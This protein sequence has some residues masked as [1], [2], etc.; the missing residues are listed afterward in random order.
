MKKFLLYG[1]NGYTA[2]LVI[3]FANAYGLEPVLAGRNAAKI[4]KL[5]KVHSLTFEVFSLDHLDEIEDKIKSYDLVL[6]CAGPFIHT[7]KNMMHAC[8][9]TQT[10]YLDITGEIEVF[11]LGQSLSE[12][13]KNSNITLIPGTGFDVVPTDCLA[14]YLKEKM[15]DATHLAL[16]IGS[17]GAVVSH[18]TA[19]TVVENIG[20][21]GFIRADGK[22]KKV[23]TAYKNRI[24]P[25]DGKSLHAMTIPWGDLSTAYFHTK[26]PNI[27]V[28]MAIPPKTFKR[29]R[30][31]RFL[32]WI[33]RTN[34]IK[35][36]L[37]K[38]IDR[39][40]AGPNKK[41]RAAAKSLIWGEVTNAKGEKIA[42]NLVGPE[43][44]TLTAKTA[45]MIAQKVL[46][47]DFKTGF[48]TPASAYGK[49][50]ILEL[51]GVRRIDL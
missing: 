32:E 51:D 42:A 47:G 23:P 20:H 44:Y 27:E 3:E 38:R 34:F 7:A 48:Q 26:I 37:K 14:A 10:H 6:H 16:G 49:D 15:P 40:P 36:Y 41:Q 28:F 33:V 50:L 21:G 18:G 46:D 30:S 29:I 25:F 22:L 24:I 39:I 1:A 45:L 8:I 43:G 2:G 35:N 12:A 4:E 31:V 5:A 19:K 13:A 17:E 9:N 11:E